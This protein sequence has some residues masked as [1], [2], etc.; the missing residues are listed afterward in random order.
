MH[1]DKYP[2]TD[3][4]PSPEKLRRAEMNWGLRGMWLETVKGNV[5]EFLI[6]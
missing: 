1:Y 2:T 6:Q 5:S 3:L 4:Y